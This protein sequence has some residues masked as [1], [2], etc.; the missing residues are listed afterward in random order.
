MGFTAKYPR[1]MVAYKFAAAQATTVIQDIIV[2]VGRTG[3][4]TPVALLTPTL[5][6]G[7]T[8]SRAT[9]HNQDE[10]DRKDI[11]VGDTV[12]IQK[13]GDVIP[14]VVEVLKDLRPEKTRKFQ[15]PDSCP[16]C[17]TK[18]TKEETIY[19][20]PNANCQAI[21]RESLIHFA[22][23]KAFNIDG[24]GE[25][26]VSQLIKAGL[27]HNFVDFFQVNYEELLALP[28]FKAKKANNLFQAINKAK[29]TTCPRLIFALGI[30][31]VG[32]EVSALLSRYLKATDLADF[33]NKISKI[34][35]EELNQIEGI[36]P[37]IAE[38]IYNWFQAEKNQQL[39][40]ELENLGINFIAEHRNAN[41]KF[42]G[43][44]FV[45]TGT[46]TSLTRDQ[47]QA[48]IQKYG[49]HI[50]ASVSSK[51]DY[52]VSGENAGSKLVKAQQLGVKILDEKQFLE[53]VLSS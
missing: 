7:S 15:M 50:V 51:T 3:A 25:K 2:Q 33:I 40:K 36:G 16:V 5:V 52:L 13:A 29:S 9:L 45:L 48:E 35:L 23:K 42:T 8:V 6:A 21:A 17:G 18:I 30:R 19:R 1:F 44:T 26:G 39:L 46:L 47:A 14:E 43:L 4:L 37:K 27:V 49:G 22:S 32:E 53:L 10:I 34:S 38:S 28:F 24:L 11:R 31:H 12:I 41:Q 20:C